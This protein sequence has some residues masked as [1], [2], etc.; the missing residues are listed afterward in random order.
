MQL[1]KKLK[2]SNTQVREINLGIVPECKAAH[3][4]FRKALMKLVIG[5]FDCLNGKGFEVMRIVDA[6][7]STI[8]K[9]AGS[10]GSLIIKSGSCFANVREI[11]DL[12][13]F[14]YCTI[15]VSMQKINLGI[16]L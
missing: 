7:A 6:I 9:I 11:E 2:D 16:C 4:E 13:D 5:Q 1:S 8:E 15:H 3:T 12:I 14:S 10:L